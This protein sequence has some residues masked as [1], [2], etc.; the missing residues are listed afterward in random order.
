MAWNEVL[1]GSGVWVHAYEVRHFGP[2]NA[3]AVQLHP[4]E[5][6]V[7]S[8]PPVLSDADHAALGAH[9]RVTAIVAP[10]SGHDLGL[11]AWQ[12]RYPEARSYAPSAAL[13]A[14]TRPG[15]KSFTDLSGL[16]TP[17]E[18][19]FRELLGSKN[20]GTL[21]RVLRG[22]RPVLYI[23]ELLG[24]QAAPPPHPFWKFA[25][26]VSGSAPGLRINR[27]FK[28]VLCTEPGRIARTL[29]EALEGEP[30]L[31]PSHGAP[32]RRAEDVVRARALLQSIAS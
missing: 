5:L 18:V 29:L 23:D 17:P 28:T 8:P 24:N 7:V 15:L 26:W 12:A 6:A 32:L 16:L 31:V 27:I 2:T 14:L 30:I 11:P 21:V 13:A 19:V 20:G 4:G 10:H 3:F 1:E 9:G 25:F 22:A